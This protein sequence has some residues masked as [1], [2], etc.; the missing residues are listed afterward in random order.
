M[1]ANIKF[2]RGEFHKLH[3]D[4]HTN[5]SSDV[6]SMSSGVTIATKATEHTMPHRRCQVQSVLTR[7]VKIIE[8]I[9]LSCTVYKMLP[10]IALFYYPSYVY[11]PRPR[12]YPATI[13]VKFCTAVKRMAKVHSGEEI[14]LK[15]STP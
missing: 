9:R 8:T 1:C 15:G 4:R 10:F 12:G 5:E 2:L 14:L 3:T 11:R 6:K 13:S 7:E